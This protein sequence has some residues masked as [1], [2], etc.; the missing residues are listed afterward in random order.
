[1]SR[2]A[3]PI[4]A[5]S[6]PHLNRIKV[7]SGFVSQIGEGSYKSTWRGL[8][9]VVLVDKSPCINDRFQTTLICNFALTLLQH[10]LLLATVWQVHHSKPYY[11]PISLSFC[12]YCNKHCSLVCELELLQVKLGYHFI[13]SQNGLPWKGLEDH[14]V[15]TPLPPLHRNE[16]CS[17]VTHPV[18]SYFLLV[19][20]CCFSSSLYIADRAWVLLHTPCLRQRSWLLILSPQ[21]KM[22]LSLFF[23]PRLQSSEVFKAQ[24][25]TYLRFCTALTVCTH[26]WT[27]P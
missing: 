6:A 20:R 18:S 14:L 24:Q 21:N 5:G 22:Y 19:M 13:E 17:F 26:K 2:K 15:P 7:K 25:K 11:I 27:S 3:N 1:V 10:E 9:S 12:W 23:R 8:I 4:S 16:H